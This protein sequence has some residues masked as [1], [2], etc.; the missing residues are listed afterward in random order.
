[1]VTSWANSEGS[2]RS[3]LSGF[4]KIN[5]RHVGTRSPDLYR[6]KNEVIHLTPFSSLVVPHPG[7][8]RNTPKQPGFGD[9]SVTSRFCLLRTKLK[10]QF[11][12]TPKVYEYLFGSSTQRR[13]LSVHSRIQQHCG[14]LLAGKTKNSCV[15]RTSAPR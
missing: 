5:G 15:A 2:C 9:E 6:V 8:L 7:T 1:M 11:F 4:K 10:S 3:Q 13:C 12:G 14:K